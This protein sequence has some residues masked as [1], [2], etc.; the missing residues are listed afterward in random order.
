MRD[1]V[2]VTAQTDQPTQ[3]LDANAGVVG[4]ALMGLKPEAAGPVLVCSAGLASKAG[5]SGDHSAEPLPVSGRDAGS[6]VREP[7]CGRDEVDEQARPEGA[8]LPWQ[9]IR[10]VRQRG[11][12]LQLGSDRSRVVPATSR[13][14]PSRAEGFRCVLLAERHVEPRSIG[15][16]GRS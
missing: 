1:K 8:V 11:P 7:T 14:I 12:A 5:T 3:G 4:P 9:E 10:H 15:H 13:G 16:G 2:T 6:D